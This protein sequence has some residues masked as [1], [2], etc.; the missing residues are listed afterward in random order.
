M[1]RYRVDIIIYLVSALFL[2]GA[3]SVWWH[4]VWPSSSSVALKPL[5]P[6][7]Q[8][9]SE[10][11]GGTGVEDGM[12]AGNPSRDEATIVVHVA[13][14]VL[15]PGV[16]ELAEGK[17]VYD[18]IELAEPAEDA[19]LDAL[20]LAAVLRDSDK[21]YVP[22]QGESLSSGWAG[23]YGSVSSS[24]GGSATSGVRFPIDINSAS[25][26]ELD[27]L[28]GIGPSLANAIVK[29]RTENGPFATPYDIVEVP[30]IGDKTYEKMA[31]LI[32]AR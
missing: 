5:V 25:L 13:G 21:V 2:I 20:N 17:R 28:P 32:V 4:G 10:G 23:G 6:D 30:G 27:A 22:R 24:Y 31:D 26:S 15:N 9:E 3:V 8:E 19:D 14:A 12:N 16:Y 29:Y 1:N 7:G 11:G 18:A